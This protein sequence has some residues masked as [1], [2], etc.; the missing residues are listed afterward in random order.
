M[1]DA[2]RSRVRKQTVQR[3][4]PRDPSEKTS[5][6]SSRAIV[7]SRAASPRVFPPPRPDLKL[8]P[9][10]LST[11]LSCVLPVSEIELDYGRRVSMDQRANSPPFGDGFRI[12]KMMA[13]LLKET[14]PFL[15]FQLYCDNPGRRGAVLRHSGGNRVFR[16]RPSGAHADVDHDLDPSARRH[17][18]LLGWRHSR[19]SCQRSC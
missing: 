18:G 16:D 8:K 3:H 15:L 14:R 11:H 17:D 12:L 13:V 1:P 2:S 7:P 10:C 19:F 6:T 9:K 4:L 5:R